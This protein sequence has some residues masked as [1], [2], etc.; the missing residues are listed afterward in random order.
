VEVNKE[1]NDHVTIIHVQTS[2]LTAEIPIQPETSTAVAPDRVATQNAFTNA[3]PPSAE[4][5]SQLL[6]TLKMMNQ[7]ASQQQKISV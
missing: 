5:Y 4:S 3:I 2:T 6:K 7:A 1:K